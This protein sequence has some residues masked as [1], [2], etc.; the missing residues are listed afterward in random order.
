MIEVHL[1]AHVSLNKK[2]IFAYLLLIVIDY[3]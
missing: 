3:E 1:T 2:S